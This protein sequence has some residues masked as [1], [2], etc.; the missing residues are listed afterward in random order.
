MQNGQTLSQKSF[1]NFPV[2]FNR[3][4][5]DFKGDFLLIGGGL[6]CECG[7]A[8]VQHPPEL[9]YSLDINNKCLPDMAAHACYTYHLY[10]FPPERFSFIQ[11][12]HY[13]PGELTIDAG[14]G[15]F[16]PNVLEQYFRFSKSGCIF[17][18]QSNYFVP[19][20]NYGGKTH[21]EITKEMFKEFIVD[22]KKYKFAI[23][24]N[25]TKKTTRNNRVK[26][27]QQLI[28][29]KP[30]CVR[31]GPF[32]TVS[33]GPMISL[34]EET[35]KHF[36]VPSQ[37]EQDQGLIKAHV[38]SGQKKLYL[39]FPLEKIQEWLAEINAKKVSSQ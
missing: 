11:F 1:L 13:S 10:T 20:M 9:F 38:F 37:S 3:L 5:S 27:Y 4:L 15:K 19:G 23:L 33:Q 24:E 8:A 31:E 36:R 26:E 14:T 17:L 22:L 7:N 16:N 35:L 6:N 32:F 12:E 18:I 29:Q 2:Y 39:T 25:E 28:F 34:N 21:G 30:F